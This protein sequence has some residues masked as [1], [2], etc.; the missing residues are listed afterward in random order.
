MQLEIT[1]LTHFNQNFIFTYN[2]VQDFVGFYLRC[3]KTDALHLIILNSF[4]DLEI[5][6][7]NTGITISQ[8]WSSHVLKELKLTLKNNFIILGK[9]L[10]QV[11]NLKEPQQ[12]LSCKGFWYNSKALPSLSKLLYVSAY[13]DKYMIFGMESGM[14]YSDK[15]FTNDECIKFLEAKNCMRLEKDS[16]ITL[17][18]L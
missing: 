18:I 13:Y 7:L 12:I 4:H 8:S 10:Q 5:I 16:E 1:N 9:D 3:K 17:K 6:N 2:R 15:E 14:L 11:T